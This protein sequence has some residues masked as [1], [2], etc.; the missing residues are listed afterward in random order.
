M[1]IRHDVTSNEPGPSSSGVCLL[2]ALLVFPV[3]WDAE[4]L[5]E[6]CGQGADKYRLGRCGIRWAYMLAIVGAIDA[7]VLAA[8]GFVL[9]SREARLG[10][11]SAMTA[12]PPPPGSVL[13]GE[14]NGGYLYEAPSVAGSRRSMNLQPVMLMPQTEPDRYSEFSHRS[15]QSGRPPVGSA[16]N[17]H[18]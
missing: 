12:P 14:V 2:V 17:F 18:L 10:R 4:R 3:G 9:S 7:L 5:R 1:L 6:V 16:H 8:L 11:E 15:A 13:R